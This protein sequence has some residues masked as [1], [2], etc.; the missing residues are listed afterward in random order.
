M[1]ALF[2]QWSVVV[3]VGGFGGGG[4]IGGWGEAGAAG[5]SLVIVLDARESVL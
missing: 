5:W 1:V 4:G 2:S 3:G